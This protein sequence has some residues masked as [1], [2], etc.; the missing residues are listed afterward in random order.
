MIFT[1]ASAALKDAAKCVTKACAE[2]ASA[3][4]LAG[5]KL[6][7][8]DGEVAMRA[9]NSVRSVRRVVAAQVEE[10][11]EAVVS[12]RTLLSMAKVLPDAAVRLET[13]GPVV[14][15]TCDKVRNRLGTL[16]PADFPEFPDVDA[17]QSVTLREE[18][19]ADLAGRVCPAAS[20]DASRPILQGVHLTVG[21]GALRMVATDSYRFHVAESAADGELDAIVPASAMRDALATMRGDVTISRSEN[22]VRF[23]SGDTTVVTRVIEGAFPDIKR[24]LPGSFA[25]TLRFDRDE[26]SMA[27]RRAGVTATGNPTVS[28]GIDPLE[29]F[30]QLTCRNERQDESKDAFVGE[31]DGDAV[32]TAFNVRFLADVLGGCGPEATMQIVGAQQPS[33]FRS[34]GDVSF[35]A[36]LMPVRV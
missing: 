32:L 9:T 25:T 19:L 34:Y 35:L 26:F 23:E 10:Q 22:Q 2:S 1:I 7:A 14:L 11:G 17:A 21:E 6:T 31:V 3:P 8:T 4:I 30:V 28:V 5:V 20:T 27:L 12:G 36:I 16:D 18:L 24:L 15:M 29:M 33:V 13:D